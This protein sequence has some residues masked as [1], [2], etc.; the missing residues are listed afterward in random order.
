LG[1]K[2]SLGGESPWRRNIF[3]WLKSREIW[4]ERGNALPLALWGRGKR[5]NLTKDIEI[6]NR[7]WGA[8]ENSKTKKK[9]WR[10]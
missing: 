1:Q 6:K 2:E 7:T 8:M 9:N 10:M 5:G 4:T 3:G